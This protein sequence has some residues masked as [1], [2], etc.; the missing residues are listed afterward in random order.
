MKNLRKYGLILGVLVLGAC[1]TVP[2]TGRKRLAIIDDSGLRQ[3]ASLAYK[4]FLS[5]P[6]VKVVKGTSQAST[7][8]RVG[9]RIAGAV[10]RFLKSNGM[11]SD[12]NYQW[13]FNLIQDQNINAWCMP[14]GKVAVFTGLMPVAKTDAGL[15]AVM[16]HEIAHAIAQ[17][18]AERA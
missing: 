13:E 15:A 18:S 3:E 10:D 11:A 16:G 8:Q 12:Y 17:H 4:K 9:S 14:G 5:D 1:A 2:L 6:E 7:V